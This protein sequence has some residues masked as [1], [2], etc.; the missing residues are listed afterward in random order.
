MQNYT[1]NHVCRIQKQYIETY[2][3][4]RGVGPQLQH[5]RTYIAEARNMQKNKTVF[6]ETNKYAEK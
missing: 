6:A 2:K 4:S 1:E 5:Y 3:T